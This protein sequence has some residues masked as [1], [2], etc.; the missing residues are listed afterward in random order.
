MLKRLHA[1][2]ERVGS[3]TR[4]G[5]RPLPRVV[6]RIALGRTIAAYD[7]CRGCCEAGISSHGPPS[8]RPPSTPRRDE[9]HSQRASV[10]VTPRRAAHAPR[11]A[12]NQRRAKTTPTPHG[13][14]GVAGSVTMIVWRWGAMGGARG[15]FRGGVAPSEEA[16]LPFE[17]CS[18]RKRF[19]S[20]C[21]RRALSLR[22][23]LTSLHLSFGSK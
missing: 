14:P 16:R 12:R 17:I 22:A 10:R 3:G 21:P 4:R 7:R 6:C 15:A 20:P 13:G 19:A 1:E 9:A 23:G 11:K 18:A 8:L 2:S 5:V